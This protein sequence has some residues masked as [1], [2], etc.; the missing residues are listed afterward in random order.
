MGIFSTLFGKKSNLSNG[1]STASINSNQMVE[2]IVESIRKNPS[3]KPL[4]WIVLFG[5]RPLTAKLQGECILGFNNNQK[6]NYFMSKY[7]K[8]FYCT[9]PLSAMA[10]GNV[11]E[12]WG[13]LNNKAKDTDYESPYGL[14]INFNYEGQ[15]YHNFAKEQL[16]SIGI[17][18]FEKG[19]KNVLAG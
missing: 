10:I 13:L 7:Q 14:I 3:S 17:S 8:Q 5:D 16:L 6:A 4:C 2:D 18:G 11:S 19:L 9:K 12:L 1:K 15:K